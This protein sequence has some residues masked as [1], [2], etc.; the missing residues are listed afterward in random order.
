[1]YIIVFIHRIIRRG[2]V[3]IWANDPKP[4]TVWK[5]VHIIWEILS[6]R[7]NGTYNTSNCL[8]HRLGDLTLYYL[9]YSYMDN[10]I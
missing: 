2:M 6:C 4:H 7:A 5:C 10:L 8:I 9:T 3:L 1:M